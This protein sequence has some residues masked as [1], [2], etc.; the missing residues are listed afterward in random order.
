M[1]NCPLP[2]TTGNTNPVEPSTDPTEAQARAST[3]WNFINAA[4]ESPL[5]PDVL[6]QM[7]RELAYRSDLAKL[8]SI[9]P[10]QATGRLSAM[11]RQIETLFGQQD[12]GSINRFMAEVKAT[13]ENLFTSVPLLAD[14]LGVQASRMEFTREVGKAFREFRQTLNGLNIPI[15]KQRELF[16]HLVEIGGLKRQE[17]SMGLGPTARKV[18]NNEY[19]RFTKQ[20][21]ELGIS[22]SV[23]D[24]MLQITNRVNQIADDVLVIAKAMG[25]DIGDIQGIEWF[26]RK[27]TPDAKR[28]L[29]EQKIENILDELEPPKSGQPNKSRTT[30]DFT[31]RDEYR[32]AEVLLGEK[33]ETR[34]TVAQYRSNLNHWKTKVSTLSSQLDEVKAQV[35]PKV[36]E[37]LENKRKILDDVDSSVKAEMDNLDSLYTTKRNSLYEQF[38]EQVKRASDKYQ[39]GV[40]NRE[41]FERTLDKLQTKR[42]KLES[43]LNKQ[44]AK[45]KAKS[46][47]TIRDSVKEQVDSIDN[48]VRELNREIN[49]INK[50]KQ[51][52]EEMYSQ[53]QQE[54]IDDFTEP[55]KKLQELLDNEGRLATQLLNLP[56]EDFIKLADEGILDKIPMTSSRVFEYLTQRYEL[57]YKELGELLITDP[58][59]AFT[60]HIR[61]LE[62]S[63]KNSNLAYNT[64]MASISEG[65]GVGPVTYAA[66]PA[67]YKG[68]VPVQQI[69]DKARLQAENLG[70]SSEHLNIRVP[71]QVAESFAAYLDI[72]T[73]PSKLSM[74][75]EVWRTFTR[76]MRR[77]LMTS[78]A[79]V[80]RNFMGSFIQLVSSG[81]NLLEIPS[82]VKAYYD[83][84][85]KGAEGL[86]NTRKV[87]A[88][89]TMT[90]REVVLKA[91]GTGRVSLH[92]LTGEYWSPVNQ[93]AIRN[94]IRWSVR[95]LS[96]GKVVDAVGDI[97]KAIDEGTRR[98]FSA[99]L[100]PTMVFEDVMQLTSLLST[101]RD[102]FG[103]R[104][105]NVIT[106]GSGRHYSN[107]EDAIRNLDSYFINYGN[108]TKFDEFMA[109]SISDFY[110]F[111]SRN[112]AIQLRNMYRYPWRFV[113]WSRLYQLW[114][115]DASESGDDLPRGGI[116]EYLQDGP[117]IYWRGKGNNWF[118]LPAG[119]IDPIADFMDM[120][121]SLLEGEETDRRKVE[122][123]L[124]E[125]RPGWVD[126]LI[127]SSNSV[128]RTGVALITQEDP[129]TGRDLT[130]ETSLLGFEV[131]EIAG[132]KPGVV[133]YFLEN[134]I[135]YLSSVNRSNPFGMFGVSEVKDARGNVVREGRPS[136]FGYK[137]YDRDNQMLGL[138]GE[139]VPM[140]RL[141]KAMGLTL[142]PQDVEM[143]MKGT[144]LFYQGAERKFN[145]LK[146]E[147]TRKAG[148]ETDPR[149]LAEY[150][151]K[152][153]LYELA[154]DELSEARDDVGLWLNS[155]GINTPAQ[156]RDIEDIQR[157]I[158]VQNTLRSLTNDT[159][160]R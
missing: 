153:Q 155:R 26:P 124:G 42:S 131:P 71:P 140:L 32:A 39:Q 51:Y 123:L 143:N 109:S 141:A 116:A 103:N 147:Y 121:Y 77:S 156:E 60:Q 56:V 17:F 108:T 62:S 94:R 79:F 6:T 40:I 81:G 133:R 74:F 130:E 99:I 135:P 158:D 10:K 48:T 35:L 114:N 24:R 113:T 122:K 98:V 126:F 111:T 47:R 154:A 57:P 22:K 53:R 43:E 95:N 96:Q 76:V 5:P 4:S 148:K 49:K 80:F 55:L 138:D 54:F 127:N 59:R 87:F 97:G 89:G 27:L 118:V 159:G 82:A 92:N 86:D 44:L 37:L 84:M 52:A 112:M 151:S 50:E 64:I 102:G 110:T 30:Y 149:K 78:S 142:I 70:F 34:R 67:K 36:I 90:L 7:I 25:M 157:R 9:S 23:F 132:L 83:L 31:I 145:T 134:N 139:A 16:Q 104:V 129:F 28:R 160:D 20:A 105:A 75:A 117:G 128:I 46:E 11:K 15:N 29:M 2:N 107:F 137:R 125:G 63:F 14:S 58:E 88:N 72:V 1:T 68:W 69:L 3:V 93:E 144:Y 85:T 146:A 61:N 106:G 21:Q 66:N 136:L 13:G 12:V 18:I 65:W 152:A 119:G 101:L 115:Q 33:L 45:E 73:D 8:V 120:V 38:A 41:Q 150:Q 100:L 91:K 19:L